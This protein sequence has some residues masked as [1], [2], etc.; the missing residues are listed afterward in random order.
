MIQAT[1][2]A[3]ITVHIIMGI[4]DFVWGPKTPK[5]EQ[6][7]LDEDYKNGW[8]EHSLHNISFQQADIDIRLAG[9]NNTVR[10]CNITIDNEIMNILESSINDFIRQDYPFDNIPFCPTVEKPILDY[11]SEL[12]I[13]GEVKCKTRKSDEQYVVKTVR[14]MG[15][16]MT[17]HS[18]A[19]V[20]IEE[21]IFR[22]REVDGQLVQGSQSFIYDAPIVTNFADDVYHWTYFD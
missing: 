13:D 5:S 15:P 6:E 8:R 10:F 12:E 21:V 1:V 20:I 19:D 14:H 7:M 18:K 11:S 3:P 4:V 9:R 22:Y 17:L 2:V 16:G